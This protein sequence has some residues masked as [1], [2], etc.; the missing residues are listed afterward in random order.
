MIKRIE[1]I[2]RVRDELYE[3]QKKID[4][5]RRELDGAASEIIGFLKD[6]GHLESN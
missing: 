1:D 4:H 6:N 3:V 5:L 2:I